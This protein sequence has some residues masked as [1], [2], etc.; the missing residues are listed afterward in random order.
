MAE[1]ICMADVKSIQKLTRNLE[2][3]GHARDLGKDGSIILRYVGTT[4]GVIKWAGFTW[5]RGVKIPHALPGI[6]KRPPLW[7]SNK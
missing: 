6:E 4:Q 3:K 5:I 2:G 1:T 7:K